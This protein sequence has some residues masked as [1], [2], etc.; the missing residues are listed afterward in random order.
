MKHF[1]ASVVFAASCILLS[2]ASFAVPI[3][4]ITSLSG[5]AESPPN[6]SLGTGSSVVVYDAAAH[7]LAVSV[8]FSGLS[9]L[10]TMSHIHCCTTTPGTGTA[11]VA[12]ETPSFPNLPL[13]VTAGSFTESF[14]LTLATIWNPAFIT[15]SGGTVAAAE[16]VFAAGL[17]AD[18]S[19][20]NIHTTVVPGGEI[21]GFLTAAPEPASIALL[22]AGLLGV[23]AALKRA[24][25]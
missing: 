1:I 14:D 21:R 24:R 13:G 4:Y 11:M 15:A 19:Y 9:G 5:A 16:A 2:S 17:A 25:G 12:T 18:T 10:T 20:L 6:P 8:V 3:T 22:T 23:A 7:S